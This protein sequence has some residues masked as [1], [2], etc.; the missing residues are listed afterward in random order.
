M[1]SDEEN[2]YKTFREIQRIAREKSTHN[3]RAFFE[4]GEVR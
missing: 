1:K 3:V 4:E 2:G